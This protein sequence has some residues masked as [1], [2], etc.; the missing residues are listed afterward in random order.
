MALVSFPVWFGKSSGENQAIY[1]QR[2]LKSAEQ[3]RFILGSLL[4]RQLRVLQRLRPR[5][6]RESAWSGYTECNRYSAAEAQAKIE[7]VRRFLEETRPG[8]VLDVG[9]NTGVFS[10]LAAGTGA[11]VVAVDYDPVVAGRLWRAAAEKNL[12]ILPLVVDIARPTPA[13]GW[14]N[15]ECRSFLDR[16][17]GAFDAVLMLAVVHHLIVTE[18]VPLGEIF[19]MARRL[20]RRWLMVEYVAPT[21]PMFVRLTRGRAHLHCDLNR[22]SFEAAAQRVFEIVGSESVVGAERVLYLMKAREG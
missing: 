14:D 22:E 7:T 6:S 11:Q 13:L 16:A 8:Q 17:A 10:M 4:R 21:D 2:R 15:H 20:T 18:R 19:R 9:C 5:K 1:R 3:A 12:P